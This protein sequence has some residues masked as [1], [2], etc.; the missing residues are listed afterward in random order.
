MIDRSTILAG[1]RNSL[2]F[3]C[4][5]ATVFLFSPGVTAVRADEPSPVAQPA[6]PVA[7]LETVSPPAAVP[8]A[9][10][11]NS[12]DPVAESYTRPVSLNTR[13]YN[14]DPTRPVASPTLAT[15]A[16]PAPSKTEPQ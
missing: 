15:P 10:L 16:A 1:T 14:Y 13:G 7:E 8:A 6:E 5:T 9:V 12:S 4:L 2:G 3:A 11:G